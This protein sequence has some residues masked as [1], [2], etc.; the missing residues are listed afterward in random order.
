MRAFTVAP[1][2]SSYDAVRPTSN[3]VPKPPGAQESLILECAAGSPDESNT[4][5][6]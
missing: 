2:P 3:T 1:A 5:T 4:K 6:Q